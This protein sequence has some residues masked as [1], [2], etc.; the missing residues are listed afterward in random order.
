MSNAALE[1][2]TYLQAHRHFRRQSEHS[3]AGTAT[4]V[5]RST[6]NPTTRSWEIRYD[7]QWALLLGMW[8]CMLYIA[9]GLA[10]GMYQSYLWERAYERSVKESTP[11]FQP[12]GGQE[13][14]SPDRRYRA[15]VPSIYRTPAQPSG[16]DGS[17]RW[18]CG[19]DATVALRIVPNDRPLAWKPHVCSEETTYT[20]EPDEALLTWN[21]SVP[22]ITWR[23]ND[24]LLIQCSDCSTD[25]VQLAK[26]DFFSGN[27]TLLGPD[28]KRLYPQVAHRQPECLD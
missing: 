9:F 5:F 8:S 7:R 19:S 15:M 11:I 28:V 18:S 23:R 24:E 16:K 26:P 3:V 1:A 25:D 12:V 17:P 21:C 10:H 14:V 22:V 13:L 6:Q 2:V 4:L 20:L 27:I